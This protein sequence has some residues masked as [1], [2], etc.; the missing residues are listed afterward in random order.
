MQSQLNDANLLE[1]T[2]KETFKMNHINV[3]NQLTKL[4]KMQKKFT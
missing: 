3:L 4:R 1:K 2:G